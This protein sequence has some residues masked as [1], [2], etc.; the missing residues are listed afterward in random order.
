MKLS[1]RQLRRLIEST[2]KEAWTDTSWKNDDVEV[3]IGDVDSYLGPHM[4]DVNIRTLVSQMRKPPSQIITSQPRVDMADFGKYKENASPD[5]RDPSRDW[6]WFPVYILKKGGKFLSV[7]DGNHRLEK[8]VQNNHTMH[9]AKWPASVQRDF[10]T[11]K[12]K[13][14]DID[15]PN[16]PEEFIAVLG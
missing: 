8:A 4:E 15:D 10:P 6:I 1:R 5:E 11:I 2:I 13:V 12:A 9:I 16:T 7:L 3:T 14:L